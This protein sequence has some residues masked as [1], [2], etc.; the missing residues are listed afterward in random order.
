MIKVERFYRNLQHAPGSPTC[1]T[2]LTQRR[3]PPKP[4]LDRRGPLHDGKYLIKPVDPVR[5]RQ[6]A[7]PSRS[8]FK[9]PNHHVERRHFKSASTRQVYWH[10]PTAGRNDAHRSETRRWKSESGTMTAAPFPHRLKWPPAPRKRLFSRKNFVRG[11]YLESRN[12]QRSYNWSRDRRASTGGAAA[13]TDRAARLRSI[14]T[15]R[16]FDGARYRRY[17][18][19]L[20]DWW[21]YDALPNVTRFMTSWKLQFSENRNVNIFGMDK[22]VFCNLATLWIN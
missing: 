21:G 13:L 5:N 22:A 2:S 1:T 6:L 19:K 7:A 16:I 10:L 14:L 11:T 8:L 9:A 3:D 4:F 17:N 20:N 15:P 18:Y 12:T